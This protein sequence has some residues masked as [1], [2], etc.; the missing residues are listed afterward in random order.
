[1]IYNI[2]RYAT[3]GAALYLYTQKDFTGCQC[4]LLACIFM[5]LEDNLRRKNE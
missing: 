3:M 5:S 1:M 2:C 4:L